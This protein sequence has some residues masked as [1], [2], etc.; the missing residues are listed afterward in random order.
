M[1]KSGT[2]DNQMKENLSTFPGLHSNGS[3][4]KKYFAAHKT[5]TRIA[6]TIIELARGQHATRSR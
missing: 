2:R 6:Q 3:V 4:E 1:A 5:R